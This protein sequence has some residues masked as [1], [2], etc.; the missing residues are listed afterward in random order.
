MTEN[1]EPWSI[2]HRI[3]H[4]MKIIKRKCSEIYKPKDNL[5]SVNIDF[6]KIYLH[7]KHMEWKKIEKKRNIN[8]VE[9]TIKD[10]S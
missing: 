2:E 1:Q 8:H 10:I 5:R 9:N 3:N 6:V 7:H 4:I